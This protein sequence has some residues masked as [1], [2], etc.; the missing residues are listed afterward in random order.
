VFVFFVGGLEV[1]YFVSIDVLALVKK[2]SMALS[3]DHLY[4]LQ[5]SW[6]LVLRPQIFYIVVGVFSLGCFEGSL[7]GTVWCRPHVP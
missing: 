7:W 6:K 1:F 2:G 3:R 4:L 5:K